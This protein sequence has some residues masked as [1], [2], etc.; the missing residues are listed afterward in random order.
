M[1]RLDPTEKTEGLGLGEGKM[2]QDDHPPAVPLLHDTRPAGV[3]PLRGL[4]LKRVE[5]VQKTGEQ[6]DQSIRTVKNRQNRPRLLAGLYLTHQR[7]CFKR[8][9]DQPFRAVLEVRTSVDKAA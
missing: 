5:V 7:P 4:A 6:S 3:S 2:L 9:N 1:G 8:R